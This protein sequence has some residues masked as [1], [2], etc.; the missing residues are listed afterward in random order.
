MT[1]VVG[2]R[3]SI[4]I[5]I[6]WQC[7]WGGIWTTVLRLRCCSGSATCMKR[8]LSTD[9]GRPA[10]KIS[11]GSNSLEVTWLGDNGGG[12]VDM[13]SASSSSVPAPH[14]VEGSPPEHLEP[15]VEPLFSHFLYDILSNALTWHRHGTHKNPTNC[16]ERLLV[17]NACGHFIGLA[18]TVA[19]W[20]QDFHF[21]VFTGKC[22]QA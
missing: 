22:W 14:S 21:L 4:G 17:H 20:Q 15:L 13:N 6:S 7:W 16:N 19:I 3:K 5:W 18:L 12:V 10:T 2:C 8:W 1:T 9:I 11:P